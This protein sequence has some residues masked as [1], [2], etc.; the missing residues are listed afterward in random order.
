MTTPTR[1]TPRRR[2]R[3]PA[4]SG[5]IGGRARTPAK[6][7]AARENGKR[8]GRPPKLIPTHTLAKFVLGLQ[9]ADRA[10]ATAA[11]EL[12]RYTLN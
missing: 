7:Q 11:V 12:A 9:A 3:T 6:S 10:F 5:R 4:E 1:K 8:G 2:P